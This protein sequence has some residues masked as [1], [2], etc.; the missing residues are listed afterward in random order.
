ML[1]AGVSGSSRDAAADAPQDVAS[2]SSSSSLQ[3]PLQATSESSKSP[4][5]PSKSPA[6]PPVPIFAWD[7]LTLIKKLH[8]NKVVVVGVANLNS[9]DFLQNVEPVTGT[10]R[11][12]NPPAPDPASTAPDP[13]S[14]TPRRWPMPMPTLGALR[15]TSSEQSQTQPLNGQ[16]KMAADKC[17]AAAPLRVCVKHLSANVSALHQK[18]M[19]QNPTDRGWPWKA[20]LDPETRKLVE[21][22]A[23]ETHALLTLPPHRNMVRLIGIGRPLTPF[24]V[25]E[26]FETDLATLLAR[27]HARFPMPTPEALQLALDLAAAVRHLHAAGWVHR[28]LKPANCGVTAAGVLKVMDF[29]LAR[30]LPGDPSSRQFTDK[31]AMT[32]MTGSLRYMA[33]E[34]LD[35]RPYNTSVDVYS[36]GVILL[37]L[38]EPGSEKPFSE[39]TLD[40]FHRQVVGAGYRPSIKHL[41]QNVIPILELCWHA[42]SNQRP[43]APTLVD[44]LSQAAV[45]LLDWKWKVRPTDLLF[46]WVGDYLYKEYMA[47][48]K[49]FEALAARCPERLIIEATAKRF[50]NC[51]SK[52]RAKGDARWEEVDRRLKVFAGT[53]QLRLILRDPDQPEQPRDHIY[54]S[55]DELNEQHIPDTWPPPVDA[56]GAAQCAIL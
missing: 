33:P 24:L 3:P 41:P 43:D 34:V 22:F 14:T 5:K 13:A 49:D 11:L 9:A 53:H 40:N 1:N 27:K 23:K 28:D 39:L 19:N 46:D 15:R 16:S 36:A 45:R 44:L 51:V 6:S 10:E 52:L 37:E 30:P 12:G 20:A 17:R 48:L 56:G 2:S 18:W 38:L 42:D 47:T 29:G 55:L 8:E 32:G 31:Y 50:I 7:Q 21:D 25:L 26:C 54:I 4:I 35:C